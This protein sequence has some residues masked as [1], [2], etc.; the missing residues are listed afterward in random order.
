LRL[1][2]NVRADGSPPSA[3]GRFEA[4]EFGE[5][6]TGDGMEGPVVGGRKAILC[7]FID[8]FSRTVPGWRWGYAEDTVRLEA[9]LRRGLTSQGVP[10]RVFVDNG[11]AFVSKPFHRT[12]AVLGIRISHSTPGYAQSRGKI[13]RFFRT[14]QGQFLIELERS[15]AGDLTELNRLFGGWLDG[16]YHRQRHS[17]IDEPPLN[18][19]M[20]GRELRRPTPQELREAFLWEETRLV[21]KTASVSLFANDYEVDAAL[22]G[23]RVELLFD[24][25]HLAEI[26]VRH[27][28][29]PMGRA[30]PR[31]ISRHTHPKARPEAAP[32]PRPSGIDY[33]RLVRER[34]LRE[35]RA[36]SGGIAYA[37]LG[38]DPVDAGRPIAD[39]EHTP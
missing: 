36:R 39:E 31:H 27:Q 25:F 38:A 4:T 32:P 2:L 34:V 35:E 28:G 8:D 10:E 3:L 24:P 33:L 20:R 5:L 6:W 1:G 12:L 9:A 23:A 13:E 37:D 14:V 26:E 11:S 7:A 21:S 17:E 30:I 16:C 19:R 18:R 15:G 29:R 22:V